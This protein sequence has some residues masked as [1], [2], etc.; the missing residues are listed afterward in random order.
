MLFLSELAQLLLAGALTFATV[1]TGDTVLVQ[2]G[3]VVA[4]DLYASGGTVFI[5]GEI[6]GD[7]V[8]L[9]SRV[10]IS[11]VVRGDVTSIS[12]TTSI[13]GQVEGSVR[14]VS[15]TYSQDAPVGDDVLAIGG[16]AILD[17]S[18]GGDALLYTWSANSTAAIEGSVLGEV[19]NRLR[20]DGAV[21]SVDAGAYR[22][23]L[24]PRAISRGAVAHNPG[25]LATFIDGFASQ[26]VVDDAARVPTLIDLPVAAPPLVVRTGRWAVGILLF[27]AGLFTGALFIGLRPDWTRRAVAAA[28]RPSAFFVGLLT[29]LLLPAVGVLI[30]MTIVL[31]PVAVVS[32]A[33]WAVMLVGG[34]TPLLIRLGTAVLRRPG[35]LVLGLL[36]GSLLWR[37]ARIIPF[38]GPVLWLVA[39]STGV[40][41]FVLT[42]FGRRTETALPPA[43]DGDVPPAPV[44]GEGD[45]VAPERVDLPDASPNPDEG[46]PMGA[47]DHSAEQER[48]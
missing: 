1:A 45:G 44:E 34:A 7:L 39:V 5:E 21:G 24:G 6:D 27:L 13:L 20:I 8:V 46:E 48:D 16:R 40:G 12:G 32:L 10:I 17:G 36:V 11:G 47:S 9:A 38:A 41:S 25:L 31:L 43:P 4:D 26:V 15:L 29:M 28:L 19:V 33:F 30:G 3:R 22:M 14:T 42:M 23:E 2:E 37:L 18:I 35:A